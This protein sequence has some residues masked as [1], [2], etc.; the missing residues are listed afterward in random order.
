ML[1]FIAKASAMWTSIRRAS[2]EVYACL[3]NFEDA[4]MILVTHWHWQCLRGA[5]A[6]SSWCIHNVWLTCYCHPHITYAFV[7][8]RI[9]WENVTDASW[10]L[11]NTSQ[12][13]NATSGEHW[14]FENKV[15]PLTN[16]HQ[17]WFWRASKNLPECFAKTSP[18][19]RE[20][21]IFLTWKHNMSASRQF[22]LTSWQYYLIP[23]PI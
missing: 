18:L 6:M 7:T 17:E 10:S 15:I 8:S 11:T 4:F 9:L 3:E 13:I 1:T 19:R 22:L 20:I 21:S 14:L 23:L 2:W 12:D 16:L 5:L